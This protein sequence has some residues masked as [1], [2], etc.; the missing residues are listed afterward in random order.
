M[1]TIPTSASLTLSLL[2]AYTQYLAHPHPP[3]KP[4]RPLGTP[5]THNQH[6][7][8]RIHTL[9]TQPYNLHL[10]STSQLAPVPQRKSPP[11]FVTWLRLSFPRGTRSFH[12]SS[13]PQPHRTTC[14][15][16]CT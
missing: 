16:C 2:T 5:C 8:R 6:D 7:P 14:L 3:T 15:V 1:T 12:M 10:H 11:P 4:P 13:A 9:Y